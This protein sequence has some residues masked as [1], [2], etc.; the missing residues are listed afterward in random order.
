MSGYEHLSAPGR[1]AAFCGGSDPDDTDADIMYFTEASTD[2]GA[3]TD[4]DYTRTRSSARKTAP[5]LQLHANF[6]RTAAQNP[7]NKKIYVMFMLA[8][9]QGVRAAVS[10]RDYL[11]NDVLP[12]ISRNNYVHVELVFAANGASHTSVLSAMNTNGTVFVD[13]K[14]YSPDEYPAVFEIEVSARKYDQTYQ[15]A[16]EFMVGKRYDALYFYLFCCIGIL[17]M[18]CGL[19]SRTEKYTCAAAVATVLSLVGIGDDIVRERLRTDKNITAEDLM[20]I[21]DS[22]FEGKMMISK[23]IECIR[24]LDAPPHELTLHTS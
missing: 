24:K 14:L 11:V 2:A 23:K 17:G 3:E 21:M 13:G 16:E 19:A 10:F 8:R 5:P 6:P 7:Q 12:A 22:A 15:F 1:F 20:R 18:D 4:S 9:R